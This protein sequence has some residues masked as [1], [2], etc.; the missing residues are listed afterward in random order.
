MPKDTI[1]NW[2]VAKFS[3][4]CSHS[5]GQRSVWKWS[6]AYKRSLSGIKLIAIYGKSQPDL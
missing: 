2:F 6:E 5:T 1:Y 4:I 3:V